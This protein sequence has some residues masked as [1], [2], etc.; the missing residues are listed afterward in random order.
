MNKKIEVIQLKLKKAKLLMEEVDYLLEKK[1][2]T[3]AVNR[4]YYSCFHATKAL[5]LT[6]DVIPKTHS[7]TATMLHQ[8]FVLTNLFKKEHAMFFS[9]LMN[10][11]IDDDYSDFMITDYNEIEDFIDPARQYLVYTS[12]LTEDYIQ[13]H[14]NDL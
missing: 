4:L 9:S 2:Y 5:L 12:T 1:Y 11:R 10:E 6:K 13:E 7:G 3:T 14:G 8:H